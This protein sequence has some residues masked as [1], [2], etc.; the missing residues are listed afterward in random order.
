[1]SN[2]VFEKSP[3]FGAQAQRTPNGYPA[4]PGYAPGGAAAGGQYAQGQP[5][6]PGQPQ[7]QG[8]PHTQPWQ[9]D[10]PGLEA[11]YRGSAAA[12]ADTGRL[13]YDDVVVKTGLVL[14]VIVVAAAF[15]W[16][17][18]GP[19]M[20]LTIGGAIVGLVLGLV[21]SFKREPSPALILGYAVAEGLF[22]GGISAMFNA[23]WE[24]IVV[25][26]VLGTVSTFVAALLL[27]TSGKVRVT[28]KLQRI[29]LV[30]LV[31]YALFSLLN[32]VLMWTG[33]VTDPW[34][35][36]SGILGIALGLFA[37]VLAAVC[38]IMD[39]D[40]IKVG[41]ER[42]VPGRY[43]WSA[44]FG[45]AVTLVWLYIEFLRLIAILRGDD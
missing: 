45:L 24:G 20:T 17:V 3:Y 38:L 12:P 25:Q 37:V 40:A 10:V 39:F 27:F 33:V 4:Y 34:G 29:V 43:A 31:G 35:L 22:L 16:L 13:T 26:A 7:P 5:Y 9:G 15:H 6:A 23:Q 36:R 44:A 1:M 30:S 14:G 11:A 2:P 18:L 19:S 42:G 32:V 28:P 21:N 41:V 8:Q